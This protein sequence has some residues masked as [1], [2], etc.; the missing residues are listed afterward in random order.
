MAKS[1]LKKVARVKDIS[2]YNL[3]KNYINN[4]IPFVLEGKAKDWLC[5]KSGLL[6]G[7]TPIILMTK[8]LCFILSVKIL[9]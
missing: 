5:K 1:S 6:I 4:S 2:D 3:R 9:P 7:Y 8:F